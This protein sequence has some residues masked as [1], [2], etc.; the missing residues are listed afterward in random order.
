MPS[1]RATSKSSTGSRGGPRGNDRKPADAPGAQHEDPIVVCVINAEH[2][3]PGCQIHTYK[4]P[5][6][7][8]GQQE[9]KT[10]RAK[11][12][13]CGCDRR[14][15]LEMTDRLRDDPV[16]CLADLRSRAARES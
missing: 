9:I 8:D 14:A 2:D 11:R 12:Q 4:P 1:S 13:P 3:V 5:I 10:P 6:V 15:V 7:A 16:H